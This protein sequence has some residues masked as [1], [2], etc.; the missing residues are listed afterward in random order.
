MNTQNY[1]L[2][3]KIYLF[4]RKIL[5]KIILLV[6]ACFSGFWLGIFSKETLHLLDKYYYDSQAMYFNREYNLRGFWA[7]EKKALDAYFI[8]CKSIAVI[9]AGG[10]REVLALSKL[11]FEVDGFECHPQLVELAN[12]LIKKEE[13]TANVY[14]VERDDCPNY[15][16]SYDGIIVGWA[17]YMLIQGRQ[18]RIEFLKQLRTLAKEK[19]P[20]LISFFCH[21]KAR[22]YFKILYKVGNLMRWILRRE[23][24]ELGD[25]LAPEYVHF[26]TKEDI[27]TELQAAGFTLE[28][29]GTKEYGHAVG[30]MN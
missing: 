18:K 7:W 4:S 19:S 20:V 13:L 9:G 25:D 16:K 8:Q 1:P 12:E 21:S 26:F 22:R 17:A 5:E 28:M 2:E 11:G 6:N 3:L 29:Y 15:G 14:L 23:L 27:A 30:I 10:G 24:L